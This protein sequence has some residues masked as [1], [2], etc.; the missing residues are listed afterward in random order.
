MIMLTEILMV[1][2]TYIITAIS[3]GKGESK[4]SKSAIH[5]IDLC[6]FILVLF[7]NY[8]A[9]LL[10]FYRCITG[11][12]LSIYETLYSFTTIFPWHR[13]WVV[14]PNGLWSIN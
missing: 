3:H 14:N 2:E 5:S 9:V 7:L 8:Y 4:R 10:S 11:F 12:Y 6:A 1:R 13:V